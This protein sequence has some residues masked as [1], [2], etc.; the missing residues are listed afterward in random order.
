MQAATRHT[1]SGMMT[2]GARF[3]GSLEF[4]H[5]GRNRHVR[6][7]PLPQPRRPAARRRRALDGR[8]GRL[9]R[10]PA[11]AQERPHGLG[12]LGGRPDDA[13]RDDRRSRSP[14]TSGASRS[15]TTTSPTTR[16]GAPC[17]RRRRDASCCTWPGHPVHRDEARG[18]DHGAYVPLKEMFPDA[19]VP[20]LQMSMPTL[21]PRGL[22]EIGRR[23]A[24]AAR[25]GHD[26]R[27]VRLH[28]PQPALVQPARRR[29]RP[30]AARPAPSSTTG[31]RRP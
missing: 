26:D 25:A 20:V 18:L 11:E 23:L 1:S 4:N 16:P 7:R 14:T 30:A 31:P 5:F 28:D 19:D 3:H 13:R 22:F 15:S 9:V 27:R 12:A 6:S 29:R 8:A 17:A 24:P 21:D 2:A 10:G